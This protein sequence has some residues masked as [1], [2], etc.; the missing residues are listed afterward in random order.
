MRAWPEKP[1]LNGTTKE[2]KEMSQMIG[3]P[4][5]KSLPEDEE[6]LR[7]I[8]TYAVDQDA[9]FRDFTKAYLKMIEMGAKY[10]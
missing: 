3:L 10:A 4:S 8:K 1:W 7:W 9:F 2:E 6:C 5:D